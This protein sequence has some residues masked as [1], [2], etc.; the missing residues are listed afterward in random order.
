VGTSLAASIV[1]LSGDPAGGAVSLLGNLGSRFAV[2]RAYSY[3]T[4]TL[5]DQ[6]DYGITSIE[7]VQDLLEQLNIPAS[8]FMLNCEC[9]FFLSCGKQIYFDFRVYGDRFELGLPVKHNGSIGVLMDRGI[10]V[11]SGI[12]SRQDGGFVV[13]WPSWTEYFGALFSPEAGAIH[14]GMFLE[15]GWGSPISC[16][17]M[18]HRDPSEFV[19]DIHRI[20]LDFNSGFLMPQMLDPEGGFA[21]SSA[22]V[23][24]PASEKISFYNWL[25]PS[26]ELYRRVAELSD[27]ESQAFWRAADSVPIDEFLLSLHSDEVKVTQFPDGG[28]LLCRQPFETLYREYFSIIEYLRGRW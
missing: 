4:Y 26:Q 27:D 16:S 28:I 12:L 17:G 2:R 9:V 8:S 20:Y 5:N 21:P 11:N 3:R 13:D 19:R 6:R 15:Y 7:G 25:D 24:Q 14:G 1:P 22:P 18:F 23:G 10:L